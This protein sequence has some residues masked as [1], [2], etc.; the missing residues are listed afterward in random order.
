MNK[1]LE[2]YLRVENGWRELHHRAGRTDLVQH[3]L[4]VGP[5][6][7]PASDLVAEVTA[8][9]SAIVEM[10]SE[11]HVCSMSVGGTGAGG[12]EIVGQSAQVCP[13]FYDAKA[14]VFLGQ[15]GTELTDKPVHVG[16]LFG[17]W[18]ETAPPG[19]FAYQTR[20]LERVPRGFAVP[21]CIP[22]GTTLTVEVVSRWNVQQELF[23]TFHGFK[24]LRTTAPLP[25]D[26]QLTPQLVGVLDRYRAAGCM[27]RVV[28]FVYGLNFDETTGRAVNA[29]E[30]RSFT[31][32]GGPFIVTEMT[33]SVLDPSGTD[34]YPTAND[35]LPAEFVRMSLNNGAIRLDDGPAAFSSV[36]GSGKYPRYLP[37]PL[38]LPER[39]TL[40]TSLTFQDQSGAGTL[41]MR[42]FV[43]FGGVRILPEGD[44]LT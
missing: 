33:G 2:Q 40:T 34:F 32:S 39:S 25:M 6:V 23:F 19:G 29:T 42:A 13:D 31:V 22:G 30:T 10:D 18:Y 21:W 38:E 9:A 35:P 8:A 44:L 43:A 12:V 5:L 27:G 15:N 14:R 24:R 7:V 3:T 36:L 16:S 11:F 17:G 37:V 28:P 20:S 26:Y 1:P 4:T 41:P